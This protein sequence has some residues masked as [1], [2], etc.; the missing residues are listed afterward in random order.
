MRPTDPPPDSRPANA[1]ILPSRGRRASS[2]S[3][4]VIPSAREEVV[5]SITF[6]VSEV[7]RARSKVPA[8]ADA[9]W[10]L[11]GAAVEAWGCSASP[12][13]PCAVHGFVESAHWAFAEHYPLVLTPDAV[14]LCIA[15]GFAAHVNENAER[16]R[17]KFVRHE[18]QATIAVRR[19]DF[20][21]GSPANPWPE[22]FG[23]FSDAIAAH[24][25]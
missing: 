12:A 18:G 1:G 2:R 13:W 15:Q 8:P 5:M 19:D 17:G 20:V 24:L 11:F 3:P 6:Q 23:A 16:L 4:S 22:V 14:W 21:K 9:S 25:G 7:E 10:E